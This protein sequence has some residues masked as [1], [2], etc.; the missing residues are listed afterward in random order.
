MKVK[1]IICKAWL[2]K[3]SNFSQGER[4]LVVLLN[5]KG[6][7]RP[8]SLFVL[9]SVSVPL[10]ICAKHPRDQ[11]TEAGMLQPLQRQ[12]PAVT[13]HR[14]QPPPPCSFLHRDPHKYQGRQVRQED[15][16]VAA[17]LRSMGQW[18]S[19]S[20]NQVTGT[21]VCS[22]GQREEQNGSVCPA[23]FTPARN[24]GSKI[25]PAKGEH[26]SLHGA[27]AA[28]IDVCPSLC[29][30]VA[31]T[32]AASPAC[33]DSPLPTDKNS[34]ATSSPLGHGVSLPCW[35][36]LNQLWL[37]S[38]KNCRL[39]WSPGSINSLVSELLSPFLGTTPFTLCCDFSGASAA[40]C[41][42]SSVTG[43]CLSLH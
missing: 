2:Y 17:G 39:Q 30:S 9:P 27:I 10:P 1:V 38:D 19:A 42:T 40:Q 14:R 36:A 34:L 16:G 6:G 25:S 41:K 7:T 32:G 11:S 15:N 12:S 33:R 4:C 43:I 24:L 31:T 13:T 22:L 35:G 8:P 37:G 5:R 29:L 26:G 18:P 20:D 21:M 3:A 23:G 28:G